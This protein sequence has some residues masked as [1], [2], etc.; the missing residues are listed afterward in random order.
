[1][2][3]FFLVLLVA[4]A[5]VLNA[6]ED[7][8]NGESEKEFALRFSGNNMVGLNL[9]VPATLL[10]GAEHFSPRYSLLFRRMLQSNKALRIWAN[11]EILDD[12]S[13]DITTADAVPTGA[14]TFEYRADY[15]SSYR[16]DVR[17]GMDWSKPDRAISAVYGADIFAGYE[18]YHFGTN[19]TPYFLDTANCSNCWVPSPFE[20]TRSEKGEL[21]YLLLGADFSI[22]C[23]FRPSEKTEVT[24][25]WTPE[26]TSRSE[27]H[28][29]SD[30]A[31]A[32]RA[33]R[34]D[35][36]SFNFRGVELFVG[37]RF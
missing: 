16:T 33:I 30:D 35:G 7:Y 11:Y 25:Q 18:S 14:N 9:T 22:G 3:V 28:S 29:F 1:M 37:I 15:R 36:I 26:I 17:V 23:L 20:A 10:M 6:Q 27:L 5:N 19:Y 8:A 4:L 34:N 2:K 24:L 12:Y 31:T 32:L 21:E 13:E